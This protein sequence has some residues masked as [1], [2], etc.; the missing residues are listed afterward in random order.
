M[1]AEFQTGDAHFDA[2]CEDLVHTTQTFNQRTYQT[3]RTLGVL[4]SGAIGLALLPH[5]EPLIDILRTI[6]ILSVGYMGI[7]QVTNDVRLNLGK[8]IVLLRAKLECMLSTPQ[9]T[10]PLF[11]MKAEESGVRYADISRRDLS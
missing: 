9:C 7:Q 1:S 11:R 2:L 4:S 5:K 8:K 6:G 3:L 10:A